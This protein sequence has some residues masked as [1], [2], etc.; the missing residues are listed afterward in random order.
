[1]MSSPIRA[2]TLVV[3]WNWGN[4]R[5][6]AADERI[7]KEGA[8][9]K[10][11]AKVLVM[12][13]VVMALF[14]MT[15]CGSATTT[16]SAPAGAATTAPTG[17]TDTTAAPTATSTAE[18]SSDVGSK[19]NPVPLGTEK[20]VDDWAVTATK[21]TPGATAAVL[22]ANSSNDEPAA[23]ETYVLIAV[24][25]K[26]VGEQESATFPM[27][28]GAKLLGKSGT[29]FEESTAEAPDPIWEIA[30]TP[31]GESVSGNLLFLLPTDEATG[32]L[33][34]MTPAGSFDNTQ[35]F[36]ALQ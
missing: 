20:Q 17:G 31:Q 34:A 14:G 33:L 4:R 19:E 22:A 15:A 1:M 32:G 28:M 11:A 18:Q 27:D 36:F 30:E 10:T 23:G 8:T 7:D 21:Y 26:Y 24:T 13:L 29:I 25:A 35:T 5:P 2:R 9:V 6:V 16:T 12:L 3:S